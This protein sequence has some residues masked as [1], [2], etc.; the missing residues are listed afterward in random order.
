MHQQRQTLQKLDLPEWVAGPSRLTHL[1][2]FRYRSPGILTPLCHRH[3]V[4]SY[5]PTQ[6]PL[7][8]GTTVWGAALA[9]EL[10]REETCI[11]CDPHRLCLPLLQQQAKPG[12]CC[13]FSMASGVGT[14][15]VGT[16]AN[17]NASKKWTR[18]FMLS[19]PRGCLL[20]QPDLVLTDSFSPTCTRG[21]QRQGR[22]FQGLPA[23]VLKWTAGKQEQQWVVLPH[24]PT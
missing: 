8:L 4:G 15:H 22:A 3:T 18:G 23:L 24:E 7:K 6:I 21:S 17:R 10:W 9:N 19:G 5:I 20:Q 14:R 2:T 12:W 11:T 13:S 16:P 1:G